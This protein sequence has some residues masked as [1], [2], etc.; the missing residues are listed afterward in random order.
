MHVQARARRV[1]A[2]LGAVGCAKQ[3]LVFLPSTILG[4]RPPVLILPGFGNDAN[5]Y[6][7]GEPEFVRPTAGVADKVL[8]DASFVL[9]QGT[10]HSDD[11]SQDAGLMARLKRRGFESVDILP[12]DRPEWLRIIGGLLDSDF[13]AGNAPPD[14]AFG[15]YLDRI[16]QGVQ[17]IFT[18]T[19]EKVLLLGHSAGGWLGRAALGRSSKL[20]DQTRALVTLGAPNRID[21]AGEDQTQGALRYVEEN[22]P[23]A[24]L[25]DQ[26]IEYVTVGGSAV[27]GVESA[28]RGTP[29]K[30]SFISYERLAGRGDVIGD[31]IVPLS[32]AH[33]D[34]A[35][36][37]TLPK[38]K[39]SIGT[40]SE[41]YGADDVID[42][43]L[44]EVESRLAMQTFKTAVG[45]R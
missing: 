32:S 19:G 38:A 30:E 23:G 40:P 33:L 11:S 1:L 4:T 9:G 5:D 18:A 36:Q 22:F 45:F 12:V 17:Q 21:P 34:G 10:R 28:D 3:S 44:P 16:D 25:Q 6:D 41:W 24:F 14:T 39:H 35:T 43:W 15:W 29:E 26:G 8:S 42:Q 2:L 37:I 20:V 7:N 31:G 27:F 13:R